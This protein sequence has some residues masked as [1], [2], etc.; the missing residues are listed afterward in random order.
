MMNYDDT[1]QIKAQDVKAGD[2]MW[3]FGNA[4]I[5]V[6]T[7]PG[8]PWLK[9]ETETES[10]GPMKGDELVALMSQH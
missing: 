8:N 5:K 1:I 6:T 10:W 7:K 2:V 9:I 4:V 3:P